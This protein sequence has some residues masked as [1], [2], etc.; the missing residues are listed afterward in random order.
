MRFEDANS[1]SPIP[2]KLYASTPETLDFIPQRSVS[3]SQR[4]DVKIDF[5]S[6]LRRLGSPEYCL[7]HAFR[8]ASQTR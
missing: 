1:R 3:A 4:E 5:A 2:R 7:Q 6:V 8:N